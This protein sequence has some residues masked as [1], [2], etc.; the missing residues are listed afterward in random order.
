MTK[1]QLYKLAKKTIKK[2]HKTPK[3]ER[4]L[5]YFLLF[6]FAID[7]GLTINNFC[8]KQVLSQ[9]V[10]LKN[11]YKLTGLCASTKFVLSPY[12]AKNFTCYISNHKSVFVCTNGQILVYQNG[13]K[14][15]SLQFNI[16][17]KNIFEHSFVKSE[18]NELKIINKS[19]FVDVYKKG[20]YLVFESSKKFDGSQL[21]LFYFFVGDFFLPLS[22]IA[23]C[24]INL[25]LSNAT[26]ICKRKT[27]DHLFAIKNYQDY[28][29][30][31]NINLANLLTKKCFDKEL[32]LFPIYITNILDKKTVK[33]KGIEFDLN[34]KTLY[35]NTSKIIEKKIDFFAQTKWCD[36][37]KQALKMLI[38][39]KR[40]LQKASKHILS[41]VKNTKTEKEKQELFRLS[42]LL[43]KLPEKRDCQKPELMSD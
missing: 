31:T 24:N 36:I 1:K 37:A 11:H 30:F 43:S 13:I 41:F 4:F 28:C 14:E 20:Q 26:K 6:E 5:E 34:P 39:Q 12:K 29:S 33:T 32:S 2:P 22:D 19:F 27:T 40:E 42:D 9:I 3:E 17:G 23:Q 35:F 8:P 15:Q 21:N 10:V 25:L 7:N 38:K 16:G 18:N